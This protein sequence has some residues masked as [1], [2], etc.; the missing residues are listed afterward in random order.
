MIHYVSGSLAEK[1]HTLAIVDVQGLGYQLLIP[2]ST[3]HELPPCGEAVKLFTYQHVREDALLLFGFISR[4]ERVMFTAMIGTSGVGPKLALAALSA[5]KPTEIRQYVL[6][7]DSAPL[8]RIPGVGRKTAER[9]ILEL[10][11]RVATLDLDEANVRPLTG[12]AEAR[13][14]ALAALEVLGFTR[15]AAERRIRQVLAK[16][17]GTR[18]ADELIRQVLRE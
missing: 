4:A 10:R 13:A 11:D 16:A 18:T 9:L 2:T 5:M 1:R 12:A 14:D 17:P 6:E 7:D 15:A 3:Y 8:T